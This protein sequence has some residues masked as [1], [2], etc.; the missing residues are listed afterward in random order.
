MTYSEWVSLEHQGYARK[1]AFS[2][3]RTHI[4]P[5]YNAFPAPL[6]IEEA[7]T[8]THELKALDGLLMDFK[9]HY[10][11]ILD[12]IYEKQEKTAQSLCV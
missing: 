9:G 8:R 4:L 2:R 1:K 6:S 11:K 10:P 7:L 5:S 3:W 12:Y